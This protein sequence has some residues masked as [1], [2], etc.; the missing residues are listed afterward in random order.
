MN[1]YLE[2]IEMTQKQIDTF[3]AKIAAISNEDTR[4]KLLITISGINYVTALT[5]ISVIVDIK[6]FATPEKLVSYA[7]LALFHWDSGKTQGGGGITKLGSAW[8]RNAMGEAANTSTRFDPRMESFYLRIVKR[9]G[10]KKA[11][12]S[13]VR[14]MLEIIW[15]MLSNSEKYRTQNHE[16]TQRKYKKMKDKSQTS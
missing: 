15:H 7:G 8:L 2:N 5:I 10:K 1:A 13:A 6:R 16:L 9:R 12:V 14:Q 3:E 11:M 4:A